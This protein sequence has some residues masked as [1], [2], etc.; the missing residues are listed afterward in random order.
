VWNFAA[1]PADELLQIEIELRLKRLPMGDGRR[2]G[3]RPLTFA[4]KNRWC[5]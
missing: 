5:S 3:C 4:K 2:A 1:L